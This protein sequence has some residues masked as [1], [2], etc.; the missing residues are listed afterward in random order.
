MGKKEMIGNTA[1][2]LG[3]WFDFLTGGGKRRCF[4]GGGGESWGSTFR[5]CVYDRVCAGISAGLLQQRQ[6][7]FNL[8]AERIEIIKDHLSSPS[9]RTVPSI[10]STLTPMQIA[11]VRL[12]TPYD[13]PGY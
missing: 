4:G 12:S 9:K 13:T 10:V 11:G 1:G 5:R 8:V 7:S 2:R 3:S 6:V